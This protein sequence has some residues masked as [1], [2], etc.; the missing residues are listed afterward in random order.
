MTSQQR[1]LQRRPAVAA[2]RRHKEVYCFD[3]RR[4]YAALLL[5]AAPRCWRLVLPLKRL[6]GGVI[7]HIYAMG[8][9]EVRVL[10]LL[11]PVLRE[12]VMQE[13]RFTTLL[14]RQYAVVA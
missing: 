1:L 3:A 2:A 10:R 5:A 13:W 4:I 14:L 11:A 7:I 6:N 12:I 8:A 9:F